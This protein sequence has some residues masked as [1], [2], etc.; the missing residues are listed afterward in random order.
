[1]KIDHP[2]PTERLILRTLTEEDVCDD[3][4]NGLNDPEVRRWL[5]DARFFRQTRESV[6]QFIRTNRESP[7][8]I[9]FGLF[10]K[11]SHLWVGTIRVSGISK[12]HFNCYAGICL[13]RKEWWGKGLGTEAMNAVVDFLFGELGLHYVEAGAY[14]DNHASISLFKKAGFRVVAEYP[15][16]FRYEKE[17]LPVVFLAKSNEKFRFEV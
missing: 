13:F 15:D 11:N 7:S 17:F 10:L 4:V 14:A 6:T 16:K 8:D 2:L 9:F 1:M 12:I 5:F 3:Y